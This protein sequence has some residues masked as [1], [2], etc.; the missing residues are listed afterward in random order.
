MGDFNIAHAELDLKNWRTSKR[1]EG[2]LSHER[3]WFG[4]LLG[5][6][7]LIDVVRHVVPGEQLSL[8]HI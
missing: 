7:T 2:F 8:I 4:S 3:E 1:M 5:P 6:R